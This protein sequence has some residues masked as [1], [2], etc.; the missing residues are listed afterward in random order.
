MTKNKL[1]LLRKKINKVDHQLLIIMAKRMKIVNQ[2]KKLKKKERMA[3]ENKQREKQVLI[4][5]KKLAK[6]LNLSVVF[7]DKLFKIIIEESKR[8]QK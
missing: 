8:V 1:E 6:K 2:I 4:R 7:V 5:L 3:I